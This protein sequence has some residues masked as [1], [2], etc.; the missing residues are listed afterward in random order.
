MTF[1]FPLIWAASCVSTDSRPHFAPSTGTGP[2]T[3]PA[4]PF[5][6]GDATDSSDSGETDTGDT[7]TGDTDTGDTDT[8]DS[9]TD[10]RNN[11][12]AS[13]L[14]WHAAVVDSKGNAT[15]QFATGEF[16][17]AVAGAS[18]PCTNEIYL[19]TPQTCVVNS[20]TVSGASD[21]VIEE[22]CDVVEVIWTISGASSLNE[23]TDLGVFSPGSHALTVLFTKDKQTVQTNF[24]IE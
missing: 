3:G 15:D 2:N 17:S 11:C 23:T 10:E 20:W 21:Q 18:N 9:D 16:L 19:T 12:D 7:D 1:M 22:N 6:T 5:D 24:V 13:D 8:G 14:I 4:A